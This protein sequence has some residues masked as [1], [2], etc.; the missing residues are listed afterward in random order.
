MVQDRINKGILK[1][2]K[3]KEAIVVDEDPFPLVSIINTSDAMNLKKLF[4]TEKAKEQTP[5]LKVTKA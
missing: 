1:F 3:K 2:P 5:I 4:I